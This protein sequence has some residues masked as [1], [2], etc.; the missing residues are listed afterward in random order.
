MTFDLDQQIDKNFRQILKNYLSVDS[1]EDYDIKIEELRP[2]DKSR[3]LFKICFNLTYQ[4]L[5]LKNNLLAITVTSKTYNNQIF[6]LSNQNHIKKLYNSNSIDYL[7]L[8]FFKT[9]IPEIE[10]KAYSLSINSKTEKN[11]TFSILLQIKIVTSNVKTTQFGEDYLIEYKFNKNKTWYTKLKKYLIESYKEIEAIPTREDSVYK[12]I[13]NFKPYE[14]TYKIFYQMAIRNENAKKIIYALSY[15]YD[16]NAIQKSKIIIDEISC[17]IQGD[18]RLYIIIGTVNLKDTIINKI[19]IGINEYTFQCVESIDDNKFKI[20]VVVDKDINSLDLHLTIESEKHQDALGLPLASST[21]K[22]RTATT[23][24]SKKNKET[25]ISVK[26][27]K[28]KHSI[29]PDKEGSWKIEFINSK[30]VLTKEAILQKYQNYLNTEEHQIYLSSSIYFIN[31]LIQEFETELIEKYLIYPD[32]YEVNHPEKKDILFKRASNNSFDIQRFQDD[33]TYQHENKYFFKQDDYDGY[34]IYQG[35]LKDEDSRYNLS[36]IKQDTTKQVVNYNV[37]NFQ[38]NLN[39]PRNEL[40]LYLEKVKDNYDNDNS[41]LMSPMELLSIDIGIEPEDI[42]NMDSIEWA[43]TFYIY[44]YFKNNEDEKITD[45]K[46]GIKVNLTFYY[47]DLE[48]SSYENSNLDSKSVKNIKHKY[49]KK[50]KSNNKEFHIEIDTIGSR[51][52]LMK[53]LIEQEKYKSLIN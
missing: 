37:S 38:I 24:V 5:L 4:L 49:S 3:Q 47:C 25:T 23:G 46:N 44:D 40:I 28:E 14:L 19:L 2:Q 1:L 32:N 21:L 53:V 31:E 50:K 10:S 39:L 9:T 18:E 30:E 20:E 13:E 41:I 42:K 12:Q 11:K 27:D 52:K 33:S 26:V 22:I 8:N 16:I 6:S 7:T 17:S 29:L 35:I 15:L 36:T 34:S 51:Y 45:K 48:D 43:D